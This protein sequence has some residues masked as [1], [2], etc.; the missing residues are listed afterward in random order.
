LKIFNHLEEAHMAQFNGFSREY[1]SFFNKLKKNNSK[2]WFEKHR[3]EYDEFVMHP[4]SWIDCP[5]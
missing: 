4:V 3:S 1:F 2:E 5:G